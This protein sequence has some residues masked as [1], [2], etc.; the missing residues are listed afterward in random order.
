M[1]EKITPALK[2]SL[3]SRSIDFIS[4]QPWGTLRF[5]ILNRLPLDGCSLATQ[6]HGALNTVLRFPSGLPASIFCVGWAVC[7]FGRRGR[8]EALNRLLYL[9]EGSA[10]W[11]LWTK[12]ETSIASHE[13]TVNAVKR[14]W[15]WIRR[16]VQ[17]GHHPALAIMVGHKHRASTLKI[18][19]A[20][21]FL[22][23]SD[24]T[25][26]CQF[27]CACLNILLRDRARSLAYVLHV[28]LHKRT[29]NS[30][31]VIV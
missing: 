5:G 10:A 20:A 12:H 18:D 26:H 4:K 24:S 16:L 7:S 3:S 28:V 8:I 21:G 2:H 15:C 17:W 30:Y 9:K 29:P 13:K 6:D 25:Y 31:C 11:Y 19:Q 27:R 22:A 23:A 1:R 14:P